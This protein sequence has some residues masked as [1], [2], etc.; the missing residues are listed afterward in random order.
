M[1]RHVFLD[2]FRRSGLNPKHGPRKIALRALEGELALP[3]NR[4][5]VAQ[6]LNLGR[7]VAAEKQR[8]LLP[9]GKVPKKLQNSRFPGMSSF[10]I[11]SVKSKIVGWRTVESIFTVVVLPAPFRPRNPY[12]EPFGTSSFRSSTAR[13]PS[14]ARVRPTVSIMV[15]PSGACE[16]SGGRTRG[17]PRGPRRSRRCSVRKWVRT[18]S[19]RCKKGRVSYPPRVPWESVRT[20]GTLCKG[21]KSALQGE[22]QSRSGGRRPRRSGPEPAW[23]EPRRDRILRA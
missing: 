9:C 21:E 17:P 23:Q 6:G 22:L 1:F 3:Q 13:T 7:I 19:T 10:F 18:H 20:P 8:D 4:N 14:Y 16:S 2:L 15:R 5:P 12:T 11:G